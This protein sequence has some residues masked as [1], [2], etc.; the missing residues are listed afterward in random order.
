MGI[1]FEFGSFSYVV[2]CGG[3]GYLVLSFFDFVWYFDMVNDDD[4]VDDNCDEWYN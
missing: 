2:C 3:G 1:L 4:V